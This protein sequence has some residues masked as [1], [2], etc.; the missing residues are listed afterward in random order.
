MADST[1]PEASAPHQ[2]HEQ[3]ND[4][5]SAHATRFR[6]RSTAREAAA[7]WRGFWLVALLLVVAPLTAH[8]QSIVFSSAFGGGGDQ[9][10][11]GFYLTS[12]GGTNLGTVTLGYYGQVQGVHTTSLTARLG[13]YDG[14]IIGSTQTLNTFLGTGMTLVTYDFGGAFVPTGSVVTFTQALLG[15]PSE[16]VFYD[17]GTGDLGAP[18]NTGVVE[19]NGTTA[20]LDEFRRSTVGVIVTQVQV[21]PEPST[22][23]LVGASLVGVVAFRRRLRGQV[24]AD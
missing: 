14:A 12:Y 10:R 23:L 15:G 18:G 13:A 3:Q 2:Q 24:K 1:A 11:R 5:L 9:L 4:S 21:V 22:F 8:A 16:F 19:T 17:H 6:V 20:P 7:G